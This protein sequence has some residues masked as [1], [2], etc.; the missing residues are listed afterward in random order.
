M[1]VYTTTQYHN[2]SL[3]GINALTMD[4]GEWGSQTK[5]SRGWGGGGVE[6]VL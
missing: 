1:S 5:Q 2:D 3:E 4:D 6:A